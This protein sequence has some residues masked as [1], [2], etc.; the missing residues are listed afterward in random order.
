MLQTEVAVREEKLAKLKDGT[1]RKVDPVEKKRVDEDLVTVGKA[2]KER[3]A[4][5]ME[6]VN[7]ICEASGERPSALFVSSRLGRA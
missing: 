1:V 5:C 4:K 3:K 6:I 7:S 2:L